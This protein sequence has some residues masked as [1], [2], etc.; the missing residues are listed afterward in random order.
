[1]KKIKEKLGSALA[2]LFIA[3]VALI[4]LFV[5]LSSLFDIFSTAKY[6]LLDIGHGSFLRGLVLSLLAAFGLVFIVRGFFANL[7]KDADKLSRFS[8]TFYI[9]LYVSGIAAFVYVAYN[10]PR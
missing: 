2:W 5:T 4:V 6:F 8:G 1:M 3:I 7:E 9:I 10:W